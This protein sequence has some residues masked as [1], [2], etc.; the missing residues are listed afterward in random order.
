MKDRPETTEDGVRL[1]TAKEAAGYLSISYAQ[2]LKIRKQGYCSLP[3]YPAPPYIMTGKNKK[4]LRYR[5]DEFKDWMAGLPKF[6]TMDEFQKRF[7]ESEA[8]AI[9][10][11]GYPIPD[12][13]SAKK[14][15][16]S[17]PESRSP[18]KTPGSGQFVNSDKKSGISF[19]V[20]QN[21]MAVN[22]DDLS[23]SQRAE[24]EK[25][26]RSLS[27]VKGC[28]QAIVANDMPVASEFIKTLAETGNIGALNVIFH[29]AGEYAENLT[30]GMA[31]MINGCIAHLS[32]ERA[33]EEAREDALALLEG[34]AGQMPS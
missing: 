32:G 21:G 2:F 4:Q 23:E 12:D 27:V 9:N 6:H 31:M 20:M 24:L 29:F 11:K 19:V 28:M 15:R 34:R 16:E 18:G 3:T 30:F 5:I 8:E 17:A 33:R 25:I 7:K 26:V 13:S 10:K 1:L 14:D 22:P